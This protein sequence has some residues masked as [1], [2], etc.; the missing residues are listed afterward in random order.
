MRIFLNYFFV[1]RGADIIVSSFFILLMLPVM[2]LIALWLKCTGEGRVFYCQERIGFANKKFRIWKFATMV[3]NSPAMGSGDIT[4][5]NDPRLL[6]CGKL[7]R[8]FKLDE[9]P[10]LFNLFLGHM[11][12]VGPRP[13][14]EKGFSR[15]SSYVQARIYKVKPG[16]TGVGSIIFR[17]EASLLADSSDYQMTYQKIINFKG[18]LELWYQQNRSTLTDIQLLF[19]TFWVIIFPESELIYRLF[20]TLPVLHRDDFID[21]PVV[22]RIHVLSRQAV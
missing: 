20:P 19:L 9:L 15:Y 10:Q 16:I 6:P 14:M 17:D 3:S 11:S 2:L 18:D 8:R 22:P 21:A 5:K 4:L 12:L 7:L 13:L 1:K